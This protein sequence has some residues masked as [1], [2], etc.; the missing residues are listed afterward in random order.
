MPTAVLLLLHV[1]VPPDA[2]ASLNAILVP[3]H[4][5]VGPV[6]VPATGDAITVTFIVVVAD[7]QN[8][9]VSVKIIFV[10]PALTP[11]NI[12]VTR[13]IVPTAVLLLLHVPV[14]PDAV[15]SLKVIVNPEHTVAGP[16][17]VPAAGDTFTVIFVV[18]VTVPQE[19]LVSVKVI[20]VVPALTPYTTPVVEPIVP[21]AMLLLLHVP[22]PPDAEASF[23]VMVWPAHTEESPVIAPA[24]GD[25]I[26]VT[27]IVVVTAPQNALVSVKII[28]VTP[29][30]TP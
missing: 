19:T 21:T 4:K 11:Y 7:P 23:N 2:V 14:P 29:A 1:P 17:M 8:T 16:V 15:A 20:I 25:A 5:D 22:V 12:P 18:V 13:S 27:F 6:M 9:L 28:F 24:N 26:T 3:V 30:L 10:T